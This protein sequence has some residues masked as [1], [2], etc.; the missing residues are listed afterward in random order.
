MK[1]LVEVG[2]LERFPNLEFDWDALEEDLEEADG[3]CMGLNA[4]VAYTA[5]NGLLISASLAL[6]AAAAKK[7]SCCSNNNDYSL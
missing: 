2:E 7:A 4:F 5:V 6:L 3:V 1:R